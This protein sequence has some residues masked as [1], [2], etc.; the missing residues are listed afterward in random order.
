MAQPNAR[1]KFI[2]LIQKYL[3]GKASPEEEHFIE[4]YYE[5][6]DTTDEQPHLQDEQDKELLGRDMKAAIW[7][8]IEQKEQ[9]NNVIPIRQ[10]IWFRVSVAAA[11]V[12]VAAVPVYYLIVRTPSPKA[13][14]KTESQQATLP[15]DA[16]PGSN[17]ATLTL[18]DGTVIDLDKAANGALA[19]E[20]GSTVSKKEDGRLEYRQTRSP[21]TTHHSP[22]YNTLTTPHGGQYYLELPDGSRV[23]LN[24]A[25]SI[26]YPTAFTGNERLVELTGEAYFEIK[27]NHEKPFRVHL[28]DP[29]T[30]EGGRQGIIE[31]LGTHFNVN[32][33]PDEALFKTTL[34]EGQVRQWAGSDATNMNDAVTLK[35]GQQA[36]MKNTNVGN[37]HIRVVDEADT[38][39]AIAWKN[40]LFYFDNVDIQAI[41]RQLAR[42]YKV[43]VVFKG[44]VPARRFAGQ[45]SR[46]SNLSQVLK[47]LELSKIHFTIEGDV[48]TVLP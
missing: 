31:V 34:L 30:G 45:V 2:R 1:K 21:L 42:W 24:A 37:G 28:T 5:S 9:H 16:L 8:R 14:V 43:Q 4:A 19:T 27:K 17:K 26:R 7:Q 44:K 35:P 32:A 10:R 22:A 48:V 39:E 13:M 11:I 18:A 15:H 20:D 23:W 47:I 38:E 36:Q 40:G 3:G 41:M 12:V 25:T 33:Y 29:S 46:S 6:F